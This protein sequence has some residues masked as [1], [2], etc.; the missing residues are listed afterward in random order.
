MV[1][2]KA[3]VFLLILAAVLL[4]GYTTSRWLEVEDSEEYRQSLANFGSDVRGEPRRTVETDHS[5]HFVLYGASAV[6]LVSAV[7]LHATDPDRRPAG[8]HF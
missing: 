2:V 8:E 6:L 7:I 4:A 3:H 1:M 5:M